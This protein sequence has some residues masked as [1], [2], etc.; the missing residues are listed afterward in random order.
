MTHRASRP[1]FQLTAVAA[2]AFIV[3]ILAMVAMLLGDPDAPVNLWFNQHGGIVLV[4][5]VVAVI[6]LGLAAMTADRRETL[7]ALRDAAPNAPAAAAPSDQP[8]PD[9]SSGD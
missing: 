3:T 4:I 9:T 2:A 7:Q 6:L 1:L 5:E 8:P